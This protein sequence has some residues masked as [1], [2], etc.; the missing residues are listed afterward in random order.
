MQQNH[1]GEVAVSYERISCAIRRVSVMNKVSVFF[2]AVAMTVTSLSVVG[3]PPVAAQSVK[4]VP[5][6]PIISK[7]YCSGEKPNASLINSLDRALER[8]LRKKENRKVNIR[9]AFKDRKTGVEC[10]VD[11]NSRTYARSI[12]KVT[13]V[14]SLLYRNKRLTRAEKGW[15]SAAI[16]VSSNGA[17]TKLW[18]RL[19]KTRG[20]QRFLTAAGM[21]RTIPNP[22]RYWGNAL[23]TARDQL[24]L[25]RLLTDGSGEVLSK[26]NKQYILGLMKRVTPSQKWGISAGMLMSSTEA[27]KNGWGPSDHSPG[28]WINSIGS[29]Q[30]SGHRYQIAVITNRN[31]GMWAGIS[32]V[33]RVSS[34]INR[35]FAKYPYGTLRRSDIGKIYFLP[36]A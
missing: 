31:R 2:L 28:W 12:I 27:I 1:P 5:E 3:S 22:G 6:V 20:M 19:G 33:K 11:A 32:V 21:T 36:E 25:M 35:T 9:V 7:K 14:A 4:P 15:A 10:Y 17:A 16:R 30:N 23:V 26:A 34:A 13:L 24:T 8:E 18:R 29:I